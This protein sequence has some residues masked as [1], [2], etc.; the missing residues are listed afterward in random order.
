MG[1][2]GAGQGKRF[3]FR[4][5][6]AEATRDRAAHMDRQKSSEI[7]QI[8]EVGTYNKKCPNPQKVFSPSRKAV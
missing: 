3:I 2:R 5:P 1:K 7:V 6:S 8:L 4:I